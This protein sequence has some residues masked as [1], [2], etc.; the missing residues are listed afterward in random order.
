M[1]EN[2]SVIIAEAQ[3]LSSM[4]LKAI[5]ET[6][7]DF[8]ISGQTDNRGQL[9]EMLDDESPQVIIFGDHPD[10]AFGIDTLKMVL[11]DFPTK[12]ILAISED[13]SPDNVLPAV[14]A[15]IHGFLTKDCSIE[16]II[17]ATQAVAKGEKFFCNTVL[18]VIIDGK[19]DAPD[20][21]PT[22]LSP[23][24]QEITRMVALGNTNKQIS[25]DLFISI[26]TVHTHRKN[27]MKKLGLH[28]SAELALFAMRTGLVSP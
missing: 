6:E 19:E 22:N 11:K 25:E 15:G 16:E 18:Q 21:E 1:K 23:R 9:L 12:K 27:I 3:P 14:T 13:V 8:K 26:H 2:Q 20:C 4:G 5:L 24:E 17:L 7:S 10:N 28:S